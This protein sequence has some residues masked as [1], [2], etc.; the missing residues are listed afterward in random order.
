MNISKLFRR[1]MLLWIIL[2]T[3]VLVSLFTLSI[4]FGW[5]SLTVDIFGLFVPFGVTLEN[6]AVQDHIRHLR[7][8]FLFY[9]IPAYA[10]VT[11]IWIIGLWL[12]LVRST[13]RRISPHFQQPVKPV[14]PTAKPAAEEPTRKIVYKTDAFKEKRLYADLLSKFQREGRFVDFLYEDLALY[15]DDQIGA[16]VRNIHENCKRVLE[17]HLK[18]API[19]NIEEGEKI[20]L[21]KAFDMDAY[22]LVGE[23]K[24]EPPFE[25]IVRHKGWRINTWA[26]PDFSTGSNFDIIQPAEIELE[27][28]EL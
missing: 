24:G 16:A 21:K 18:L 5:L 20:T 7:N 28:K 23:V 15:T 14:R 6:H 13:T 25:G 19:T 9:G 3:L 1:S 8:I 12:V 10:A 26:M 4:Y 11:A 17:R 2:F 22:S 27:W